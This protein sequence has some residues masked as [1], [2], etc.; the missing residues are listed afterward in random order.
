MVAASLISVAV[1][2]TVAVMLVNRTRRDPIDFVQCL[3][4]AADV[5]SKSV[6]ERRFAW[7]VAVDLIAGRPILGSGYGTYPAAGQPFQA[8]HMWNARNG[9][10]WA[11]PRYTHN[12]SLQTAAETGIIGLVCYLLV[13]LV[14]SYTVVVSLASGEP[15]DR[16][17]VAAAAG[18]VV[19]VVHGIVHFPLY[20]APTALVFWLLLGFIGRRQSVET[21][22]RPEDRGRAAAAACAIFLVLWGCAGVCL[23]SMRFFGAYSFEWA[24]RKGAECNGAS[25]IALYERAAKLDPSLYY[26]YAEIARWKMVDAQ[27]PPDMGEIT[28]LMNK[29]LT[30]APYDEHLRFNYGQVLEAFGKPDDA[31]RQFRQ[32]RAANPTFGPAYTAAA[33]ILIGE[34]GRAHV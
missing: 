7:N 1:I 15:G 8:R 28:A 10:A 13:L 27:R 25:A 14:A 5:E 6:R 16:Y 33:G 30:R 11:L 21:I 26:A 32:A 2:C 22:P 23:S 4:A 17:L 20:D 9:E 18:V 12:D 34:I 19:V 29:A 3:R 31:L 24:A